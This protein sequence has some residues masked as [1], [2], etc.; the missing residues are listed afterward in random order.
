MRYG[1]Y[2]L[3]TSTTDISLVYMPPTSKKLRGHIGLGVYVRLSVTLVLGKE[4]LEKGSCN[5]VCGRSMKIKRSRV[6]SLSG[7]LVAAELYP[8]F[9]DFIF[10]II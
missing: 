4:P 6:F 10:H 7:G 9:D 3:S 8:F 2:T 1:K 5:L